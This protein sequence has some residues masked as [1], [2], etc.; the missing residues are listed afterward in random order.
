M[1][2]LE[3]FRNEEFGEVRTIIKDDEVLFCGSDVAKALGYKKPSDAI[4]QHCKKGIPLDTV[5]PQSAIKTIQ[6]IFIL[7]SDV[8]RLII[9]SKLPQVEKFEEWVMEEVLP[10]IRKNGFYITDEKLEY[11]LQEN[12]ENIQKTLLKIKELK[13]KQLQNSEEF[14]PT[15]LKSIFVKIVNSLETEE[16]KKIF[17]GT[18]YNQIYKKMKNDYEIDLAKRKKDSNSDLSLLYFIKE[19]EFEKLLLCL[20]KEYVQNKSTLIKM[21]YIVDKMKGNDDFGIFIFLEKL[22][23]DYRKNNL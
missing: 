16:H 9:K 13:L 22:A 19:N 11:F 23:D 2:E 18:F 10:S 5:H 3:I 17:T 4:K 21:E 20:F 12:P 15:E 1:N 14:I 6:M 7:E 8:Y